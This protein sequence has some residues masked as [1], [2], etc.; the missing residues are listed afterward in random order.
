MLLCAI[1][2]QVCPSE[3]Q[4]KLIPAPH[5]TVSDQQLDQKGGFWEGG[6]TLL[7]LELIWENLHHISI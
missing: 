6:G 5:P 3:I 1:R 2:A 4:R 7:R